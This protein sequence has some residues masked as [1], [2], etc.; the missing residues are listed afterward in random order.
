[1]ADPFV[2]LGA[3]A[4]AVQFAELTLGPLVK[5]IESVKGA[6]EEIKSFAASLTSLKASID[7]LQNPS[8]PLPQH[9]REML[10][11]PPNPNDPSSISPL[12]ALENEMTRLGNIIKKAQGD[13]SGGPVSIGKRTNWKGRLRWP[14]SVE[15]SKTILGFIESYKS[16]FSLVLAREALCVRIL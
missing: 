13:T 16:L 10:G 7:T 1:M 4:A 12:K 9:V 5:N 8:S 11:T 3:V 15:E 14:F 6:P 2:I